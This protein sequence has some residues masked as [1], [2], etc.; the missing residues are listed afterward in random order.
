MKKK[1]FLAIL[2]VVLLVLSFFLGVQSYLRERV[3]TVSPDVYV[4]VD[5]AYDGVR[6]VENL[7]DE[8]KNY[9]NFFVI[10]STGISYNITSLNEVSQYVYNSGLYF[11]LFMHPTSNYNQ[12]QWVIDSRQKWGNQFLGLYA[13]DEAGGDQIDRARSLPSEGNISFMMVQQAQNY[14]DASEKYVENLNGNLT[15]FRF[16]DFP[17]ITSDY[18]LYEFDYRGGYDVV[19]AQF[20]WNFSRPLEV[21]LC[22]GAATAHNKDWGVMI[23]WTFIQ[24]PYI[25]N[26]KQLYDDMVYAYQNGA[27]YI[28]VFDYPKNSTYG[29]LEQDHL[30]AIAQF[31]QYVKNNPRNSGS[32]DNRIAYVLPKDYG[33]GFRGSDDTIWGIW[34]ADNLSSKIWNDVNVLLQQYSSR[35]D[36]VYEDSLQS[37][38]FKYAKLIF[39][40]GTTLSRNAG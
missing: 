7:V 21:A 1:Y 17:L 19:L 38:A 20:G 2:I 9:T 34:P 14:V 13:Y 3:K 22:R 5:A 16:G 24:S 31:W 10:G 28:L 33:Y 39:W 32:T 40:N 23:T 25:E 18:A 29:I 27:K 37:S 11:S 30:D 26:G 8:V 12:S 15:V 35:M 4:G 6:D 36:I